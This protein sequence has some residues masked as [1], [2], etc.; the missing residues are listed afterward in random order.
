MI[1][2]V[3]TAVAL[4]GIASPALAGS[5]TDPKV[6]AGCTKH[7]VHAPAGKMVSHAPVYFCPTKAQTVA[8][9]DKLRPTP[10]APVVAR[11]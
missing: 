1:R 2:F 3:I 11:D 9:N 10:V 8:A 6:A 5:P 4:A 7:Q